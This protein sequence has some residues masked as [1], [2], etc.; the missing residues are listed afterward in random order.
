MSREELVAENYY[1][2]DFDWEQLRE[3]V[4]NDPSLQFHLL[5]CSSEKIDN[6]NNHAEQDSEAWDEF[7]ARHSTGK[8][9]KER[10][11]L[12]KE[13][14]ELA[15]CKDYSKVLEVGCGNGST[16][17]AILRGRESMILYACDCSNEALVRAKEIIGAANSISD[18]HRFHPFQNDFSTTAFPSW[19]ACNIC[20]G[21]NSSYEINGLNPSC[22]DE[23]ECCI[24]GVDFVT[25]IF[26]LSALP[27]DRMPKALAHCF[28]VLKPG[29]LLLFRDYGLYDMTMLRFQPEQKMGYREYLRS[30]GTRSYFFCLDTVRNLTSAAGF[31][32]DGIPL[33]PL[34]VGA[35]TVIGCLHTWWIVFCLNRTSH[36]NSFPAEIL[37]ESP[38]YPLVYNHACR[39]LLAKPMT[40]LG[41]TGTILYKVQPETPWLLL[42]CGL[43]PTVEKS[44]PL[45]LLV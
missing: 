33:S 1:S 26:T 39:Q 19:L 9:F 11:Y 20:S 37:Q 2:K 16:A 32:E 43:N 3:E 7:H 8:F 29:G 21:A 15:A 41:A 23:T 36:M 27:L 18:K 31:T 6:L 14:P 22:S 4:E 24:G 30:D 10:R 28:A 42:V 38:H 13:F 40:P 45:L 17:L 5:P 12:L 34:Y 44:F 35:Q 25:L